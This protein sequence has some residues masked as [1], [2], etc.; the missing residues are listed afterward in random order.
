MVPQ[1]TNVPIWLLDVDGV[2]NAYDESV[3]VFGDWD[4][5]QEFLARGFPM[6]YSPAM[7]ARILALHTSGAVEVRWLTTWGRHAN[8]DLTPFGF[9][10]FE[11]AGEQPF[12]ERWG[13]WKLPVAQKLFEQGHAIIWT[14]DDLRFS[15]EAKNWVDEVMHSDRAWDMCA[16]SPEGALSQ[17]IM[18][19]IE[20]WLEARKVAHKG[21]NLLE[22]KK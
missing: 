13:W 14:D 21:F 22:E 7:C 3:P 11:V 10:Q 2:L 1:A 19:Q 4:D 5:W 6:R 20:T 8:E 16:F 9:P 15:N 12:R 17:D 18:T